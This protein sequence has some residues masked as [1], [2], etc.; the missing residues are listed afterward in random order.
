MSQHIGDMGSLETLDAFERST[1]QFGEIY[2]IDAGRLAADAHPG[3]QTRRWAEAHGGRDSS[4]SSST[5]TPT[6]PR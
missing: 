2:G 5:T 3:Y 1:R 6:S 4:R